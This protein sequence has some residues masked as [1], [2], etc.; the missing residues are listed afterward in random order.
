MK[1]EIEIDLEIGCCWISKENSYDCVCYS[2]DDLEDI[3]YC[4]TGFLDEYGG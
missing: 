3:P 1:I 2:I 4:L